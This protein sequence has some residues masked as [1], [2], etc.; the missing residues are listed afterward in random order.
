[1]KAYEGMFIFKPD[2]KKEDVDKVYGQVQEIIEKH[3]GSIEKKDEWGKKSLAFP[4][5][6]CKEGFYYLV[7]FHIEPE[8][9]ST[10]KRYFILNESILRVLII[11]T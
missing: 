8:S 10:I 3:K 9:I 11:A 7:N 6:K 5:K 2:L 4:I 1:M